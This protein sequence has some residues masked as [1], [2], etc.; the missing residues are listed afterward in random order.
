MTSLFINFDDDDGGDLDRPE[1]T[2]LAKWLNYPSTEADITE[3]FRTQDTDRSGTLSMEEF[4]AFYM[5]KRPDPEQLYGL[6]QRTYNTAL[7]QFRSVDPRLSG[8]LDLAAFTQLAKKQQ[9]VASDAEAAGLFAQID[10]DQNGVID[11]HE[12][13]SYMKPFRG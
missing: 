9:V 3:M 6:D 13:L 11:L 4:L 8:Y 1:V 2:R 5:D 7:L 10:S 12:F